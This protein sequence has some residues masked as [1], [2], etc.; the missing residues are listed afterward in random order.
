M[1]TILK[2]NIFISDFVRITMFL[3]KF[4]LFFT[5]IDHGILSIIWV[6]EP[7]NEKRIVQITKT[8]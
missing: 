1:T 8:Y 5:P 2:Y 3:L 7:T 4:V 6:V